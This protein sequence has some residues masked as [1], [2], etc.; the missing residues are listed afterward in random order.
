MI[1]RA[2]A[3]VVCSAAMLAYW[4]GYGA[5]LNGSAFGAAFGWGFGSAATAALAAI[6]LTVD[7]D[8]PI[9]I[10]GGFGLY[11]CMALLIAASANFGAGIILHGSREYWIGGVLGALAGGA[12][13]YWAFGDDRKQR[14]V[15]RV[16]GRAKA[17]QDRHQSETAS[18]TPPALPRP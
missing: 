7:R 11:G 12:L 17:G 13:S 6:P 18:A 4:L 14:G 1:R 10:A 15:P 3:V 5:I 2:I 16:S 9:V 8:D